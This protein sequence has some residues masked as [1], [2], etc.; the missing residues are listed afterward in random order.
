MISIVV[1]CLNAGER[2]KNT[3]K[4][5]IEQSSKD[6]E[7]IIQDGI[8]TDS[9]VE[10]AL[11]ICSDEDKS[12][13]TVF[14]QKDAGIYDA[15]N[16]AVKKIKGQ[17]CIFMNAGDYLENKDSLQ[18][19][20]EAIKKE[21][22]DI[23]YGYMKHRALNT[24]VYPSKVIDD[25]TCFRNV[26]CHQT[27]IYSKELFEKRGYNL[28]YRV[29][30]DYEHF[31]WCYYEEKA[32]ITYIDVPVCSY[33]GGGFSETRENKRESAKEHREIVEK[34]M[35]SKKARHYRRIMRLT[36]QPLRTR[37]A[38]SKY[39]SGFYNQVKALIYKK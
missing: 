24:Y 22:A 8:S 14:S 39:M 27:C 13:I 30:A 12:R 19:I 25:F 36:L 20:T 10:E 5:I 7:V 35:G 23:Y 21:K 16:K 3:I 34:Y 29:R 38:Q 6:Y 33:E 1:V 31:L 26:P 32:R 2:L 11:K 17:Y 15:M 18:K 9:S 28:N 37:M 4:S